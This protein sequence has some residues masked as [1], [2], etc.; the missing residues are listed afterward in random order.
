MICLDQVPK[1]PSV[2]W[3]SLLGLWL[4]AH[5][6]AKRRSQEKLPGVRRAWDKLTQPGESKKSWTPRRRTSPECA[7]TTT[8][9]ASLTVWG[10]IGLPLAA[11][12]QMSRGVTGPASAGPLEMLLRRHRD[13]TEAPMCPA[14][15]HPRLSWRHQPLITRDVGLGGARVRS[16]AGVGLTYRPQGRPQAALCHALRTKRAAGVFFC[17]MR[18]VHRSDS[19]ALLAS[20][21]G[22]P[23]CPYGLDACEAPRD[24][25]FKASTWHHPMAPPGCVAE[26]RLRGVPVNLQGSNGAASDA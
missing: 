6:P 3:G 16:P 26:Q 12:S 15:S 20:S 5:K 11:W 24:L 22:H 19:T 10:W 13:P 17:R 23:V 18:L 25:A 21:C 14:Q 8:F 4:I 9:R 2:G 7:F 1:T